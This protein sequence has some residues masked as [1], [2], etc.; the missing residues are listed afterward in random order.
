MEGAS[1]T[2]FDIIFERCFNSNIKRI[3]RL[4]R[5]NY[6]RYAE[7]IYDKY[8]PTNDIKRARNSLI[9]ISRWFIIEH[10]EFSL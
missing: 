3:P 2:K 6:E 9:R 4:D 10:S 7:K 8:E 5:E 1:E